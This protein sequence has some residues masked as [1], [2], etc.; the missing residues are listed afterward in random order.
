MN[1]KEK[2]TYKLQKRNMIIAPI[3][4]TGSG[5]TKLHIDDEH[6]T[7]EVMFSISTRVVRPS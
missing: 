4:F 1:K 3:S 5:E 7:H 2:D 6:Y